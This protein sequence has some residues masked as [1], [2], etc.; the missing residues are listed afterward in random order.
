MRFGKLGRFD[1]TPDD[2]VQFHEAVEKEIMPVVLEL[3][4]NR[5]RQLGLET[6]RPMAF[7]VDPLN[8]P[9]LRPFEEVQQMTTRTAKIFARLDTELAQGLSEHG[10]D[11]VVGSGQW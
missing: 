8:R 10:R 1:Y 6:L 3:Q 2:C 5:R 4:A 11:A 7:L 9:P